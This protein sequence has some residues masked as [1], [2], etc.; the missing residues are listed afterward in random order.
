MIYVQIL[1][2]HVEEKSL[3]K[4]DLVHFVLIVRLTINELE[5]EGEIVLKFIVEESCENRDELLQV[6]NIIEKPIRDIVEANQLD[7]LKYLVVSDSNMECFSGAVDKYAKLLN[8]YTSLTDT[9]YFSACAK[10]L[11]GIMDDGQYSQV[12][13][14]KSLIICAINYAM[15]YEAIL[16]SGIDQEQIPSLKT[17]EATGW[18]IL[19]HE[20]GHAVDNANIYSMRHKSI[21]KVIF[22]IKY[23]FDEL[24]ESH[25]FSLWG[26]YF[27]E[28]FAS[29]IVQS[30]DCE[31]TNYEEEL[32]KCIES[33]NEKK[34][35]VIIVD[36]IYRILYLF[37]H[38]IAHRH[39]QNGT[40]FN[41]DKFVDEDILEG[42]VPFL[43]RTEIA[44]INLI[45]QYPKWNIETCMNEMSQIIKD[46][47]EFE[48]K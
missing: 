46:M 3:M 20:I 11:D 32:K 1:A 7:S 10:T 33:H 12:I 9:G 44:M 28:V 23:E 17:C 15:N 24:I 29:R 13:I 48:M 42:Y 35:E 27:A 40:G 41:Y 26:E 18:L 39:I 2:L 22:D 36:K 34:T 21:N 4:L 5:C 37:V 14:V 6:I 45:Q 43:A 30:V 16:M 31:D 38:C 8:V 25:A 47:Y 19:L